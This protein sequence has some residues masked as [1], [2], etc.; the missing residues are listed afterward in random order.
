MHHNANNEIW[1]LRLL[2]TRRAKVC[3]VDVIMLRAATMSD[4]EEE[5]AKFSPEVSVDFLASPQ[6][7]YRQS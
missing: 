3:I 1:L 7:I 2:L 6:R 4:E 5:E